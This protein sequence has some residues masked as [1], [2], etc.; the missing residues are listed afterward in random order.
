VVAILKAEPSLPIPVPIEELCRQR[1]IIGIQA[2][3]THAFEDGL[4]TDRE[5]EAVQRDDLDRAGIASPDL[6]YPKQGLRI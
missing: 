2:L 3:T 1:D 6:Q 4:L 5:F